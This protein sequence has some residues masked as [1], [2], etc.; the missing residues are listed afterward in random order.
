MK[1]EENQKN[2]ENSVIELRENYTYGVDL[3]VKDEEL[4]KIEKLCLEFIETTKE[5]VFK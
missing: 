1:Y 4:N 2:Y 5:I 3:T